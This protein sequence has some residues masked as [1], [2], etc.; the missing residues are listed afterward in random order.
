MR[1]L[2]AMMS[3]SVAANAI[4]TTAPWPSLN[5][6]L[7]GRLQVTTPLALPC[8]SSYNGQPHAI[9]LSSCILI[10][11]NYTSNTL[12][13]TR[14]EA[15]MHIQNEMCLSD[16]ADECVLDDTV[17]PAPMPSENRT[18]RQGSV[19]SYHIVIDSA[20]DV[21]TAFDFARTYGVELSVKNAGH[22]YMTRG[23]GRGTLTIYTH[24]LTDMTFDPLLVP[25]GCNTTGQAA[26]TL[27][28]GVDTSTAIAFANANNS[29]ILTAYSPTVPVSTGWVLGAG[30]SVLS[31]VY[32]LGADRVLSYDIVTPDGEFRTASACSNPELFWALRGGG[33]GTFGVVLSATH[34]VEPKMP[35]AMANIKLPS[36]ATADQ[37]WQ[38]I[39]LMVQESLAWGQAGWGG[40]IAGTYLTHF[41][42]LPEYTSDGGTA[43]R[44]AFSRASAFVESIGGTSQIVVGE[45]FYALWSEYLAPN[46]T[47]QGAKAQF[48]SNR[49]LSRDLFATQAGQDSIMDFL[50]SI[51][52]IGFNPTAFYTPVTTPFV[53]NGTSADMVAQARSETAVAP[54]WYDALC[55]VTNKFSFFP[56]ILTFYIGSFSQGIALPWNSTYETRLSLLTN[57]TNMTRQAEALGDGTPGS[58]LNEANPFMS[59]WVE[60]WWGE[61][62]YERLVSVKNTYDPDGLL[63]CWKCVGFNETEMN[64][65]LFG[66]QAKLQRDI[67]A[68]FESTSQK[69]EEL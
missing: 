5:A 24:N 55:K 35:V 34:K 59:D 52:G 65:D 2:A 31:P 7:A 39:E 21:T 15:Y 37:A 49:L 40:H 58:Y 64:S 23:A 56:N 53:W 60:S 22:D 41:N 14:V 11:D 9:D 63:K 1:S 67:D 50:R 48:L 45:S 68:A 13:T 69:A 19:P 3:L 6:S 54:A 27:A 51:A 16:P 29:T 62:N 57:L 10:R 12:R 25:E 66:C 4:M 18:C 28:P 36:N 38:W 32:G 33:G 42:P 26:V 43:A 46:F 8:F 47:A 30:H 61:D 20:S 17:L 44:A